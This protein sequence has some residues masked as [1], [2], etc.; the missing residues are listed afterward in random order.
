VARIVAA[1]DGRAV[2]CAESCT[3]GLLAQGFAKT[4]GSADW[5]PG[6]IVTYQ[7][8]AKFALLGV[9]PGP[10]VTHRA[11]Q[12]MARG[13]AHL[14]DAQVA[15]SITGAAGPEPLDGALPGTIIIGV[16]H[17]GIAHSREYHVG[18]TAEAV[19]RAARDH[20]LR[21]LLE[22]WRPCQ[23]PTR[24]ATNPQATRRLG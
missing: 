21:D 23:R 4:E 12:Q 2:T 20:A 24:G 1:L 13:V 10:V 19:C 8:R 14:F 17:D 16:Y 9:T 15:V 11:A 3:G 6:G 22:R 18:G 7:P 5:F